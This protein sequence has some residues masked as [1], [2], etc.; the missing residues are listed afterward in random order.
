MSLLTEN[1][2]NKGLHEYRYDVSFRTIGGLGNRV[3]YVGK[4]LS[5]DSSF[6]REII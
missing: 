6:D 1:Q 5:K 2:L 4:S 3:I